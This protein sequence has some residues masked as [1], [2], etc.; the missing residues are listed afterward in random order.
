M[1]QH[2]FLVHHSFTIIVMDDLGDLEFSVDDMFLEDMFRVPS[3]EDDTDVVVTTRT[4]TSV[5][6]VRTTI[7]T[8]TSRKRKRTH[9]YYTGSNVRRARYRN[10]ERAALLKLYTLLGVDTRNATNNAQLIE[11]AVDKVEALRDDSNKFNDQTDIRFDRE[12]IVKFRNNNYNDDMIISFIKHIFT[13]CVAMEQLKNTL[14]QTQLM[15]MITTLREVNTTER[16]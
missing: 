15:N 9:D 10:R 8:V 5:E 6:T 11:S 7:E 16:Y 12:D 2:T 4:T 13:T 3:N 14:N 1:S